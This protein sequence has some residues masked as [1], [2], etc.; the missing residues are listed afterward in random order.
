MKDPTR[1]IGTNDFSKKSITELL[2]LLEKV[3]AWQEELDNRAWEDGQGWDIEQIN[4]D[5]NYI[6]AHFR[7][8][9][10]EEIQKRNLARAEDSL[11]FKAHDDAISQGCK[12]CGNEWKSLNEKGYC[13]SCW[14]VWNS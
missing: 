14:T 9:L 11:P 7:P 8:A 5:S 3:K 2:G 13:S 12:M 6:Q 1:G 10:E 4:N